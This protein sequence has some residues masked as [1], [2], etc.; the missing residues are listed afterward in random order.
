MAYKKKKNNREN[1]N[2]YNNEKPISLYDRL[3]WLRRQNIK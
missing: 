2:I 3:E 1:S